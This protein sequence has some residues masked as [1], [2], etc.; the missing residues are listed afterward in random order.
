MKEANDYR[1]PEIE[2][3]TMGDRSRGEDEAEILRAREILRQTLESFGIPGEVTGHVSGPR[4]TRFELTLAPG[5]NVKKVEK[6]ADNIAMNLGVAG[7][8]VLA[9][10]PERPTVGID[11]PNLRGEAVFVRSVMESEAWRSGKAELPIAVGENVAGQ[12]VVLD[13]AKAPQMLVSG[14]TGTGKNVCIDAIIAS[15]LFKFRP[16]ELKFVMIDPKVIGLEEYRKLPHLLTPII[17]AP[18]K[19]LTALRWLAD[20]V[21]RRYRVMA[22]VHAKKLSEFNRRPPE[23]PPVRDTDGNEIPP[24]MPYLVVMID[25]LADL[26]VSKQKKAIESCITRI[27]Q[28]G[29]AAGIHLVIATQ[30]PSTNIITGVIKANLP[31]RLC[32]Q[33]RSGADSR[34]VIDTIGAE[35]LLGKGDI[36][37][38]RPPNMTLERVQGAFVPKNDIRKLVE[39]ICGQAKPGF[40]AAVPTETAEI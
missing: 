30:R 21:D 9:P 37:L 15:L 40:A 7:V 14:A 4:V 3:L 8:R 17:T 24:E 29:R 20:E 13:L 33:V 18:D 36:L 35:Q 34:V 2:M 38:M 5:V 6:I 11:V 31:T 16:D 27:A 39:F 1:L 10:I 12:P 25:E 28:K 19:A 26:M 23:T 32:F 22:E